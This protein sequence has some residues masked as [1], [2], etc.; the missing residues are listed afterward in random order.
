MAAQ[1]GRVV[2]YMTVP[3]AALL[4]PILKADD[5]ND[6]EI[7]K[8][9]L[10]KPRSLPV[11]G[12]PRPMIQYEYVIDKTNAV[13][14]GITTARKYVW[15]CTKSMQGTIDTVKDVYHKG[16]TITKDVIEYAQT[17]EGFYPRLVAISMAGLV[18]IV[19]GAKG[20]FTRKLIYS[21]GLMTATASLCYPYQAVDIAQTSYEKSKLKAADLYDKMRAKPQTKVPEKRPAAEIKTEESTDDVKPSQVKSKIAEPKKDLGQSTPEDQDMYTTRS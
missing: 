3:S 21:G 16:E 13:Q 14:D 4:I 11:Y 1:V 12:N 10:L 7:E 2:R 9:N 5:T 17:E 6:A 20:G 19:L 18:G 8:S 15:Q